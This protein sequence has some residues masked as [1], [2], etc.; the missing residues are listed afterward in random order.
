MIVHTL[1]YGLHVGLLLLGPLR[2][3]ALVGVSSLSLGVALH[4]ARL[5]L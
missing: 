2:L 1:F 3:V 5:D 4:E